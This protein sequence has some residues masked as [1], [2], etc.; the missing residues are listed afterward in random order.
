M[1]AIL[2]LLGWQWSDVG[3]MVTDEGQ[4]LELM[5]FESGEWQHTVRDAIRRWQWRV[6][7]SRRPDMR[8]ISGGIDRK[9]TL[10]NLACKKATDVRK[11]I[12]R[13]IL[14]GAIWTQSRLA[15]A[16]L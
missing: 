2:K 10:C 14:S 1:W 3:H 4:Q 5:H 8:G 6:A 16:G 13:S 15:N 7:D 12:F 9:A 11:G